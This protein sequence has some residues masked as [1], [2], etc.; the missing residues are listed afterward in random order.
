MPTQ[1]TEELARE[2]IRDFVAKWNNGDLEGACAMYADDVSFVT[3]AGYSQGKKELME[4]YRLLFPN[5]KAM[6]TLTLEL[7]EFR[8][9]PGDNPMM[10]TAVLHWHVLLQDGYEQGHCL[11]TYMIL[12]NEFRIV[13]DAT[14]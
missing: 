5:A 12:N 14:V 1:L 3:R 9:A 6:G 13:Q 4:R 8:P 2:S 7:L 10:A 11:E